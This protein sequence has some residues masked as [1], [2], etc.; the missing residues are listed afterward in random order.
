MIQ[1]LFCDQSFYT[2]APCCRHAEGGQENAAVYLAQEHE[3]ILSS[4]GRQLQRF[5]CSP[6]QL[7]EL[8]VGWLCG[9]GYIKTA[10]DV[11]SLRISEDGHT[12]EVSLASLERRELT[13]F[14][15][16]APVD[17][18]LCREAADRL[19]HGDSVYG[20]TR[21]THGCVYASGDGLRIFCE[22]IGRNNAMDKTIGS[23]LLQGGAAERGLL[24]SSG[25][26]SA[27]IAKKVVHAGIPV[28]VSKAAVT[29]EA[30]RT[31]EHYRLRLAFFADGRSW[32]LSEDA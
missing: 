23:L 6:A 32:L 5:V 3:L 24:F 7:P 22:D 13:A 25:R 2:S 16:A 15:A 18:V 30:L 19:L 10:E 20:K 1:N 14:P 11:K 21:G 12:A 27:D 8:C 29:T 26:V 4:E 9:E 28:L 31:A 17:P